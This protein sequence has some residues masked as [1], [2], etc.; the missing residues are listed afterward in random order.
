MLPP[1]LAEMKKRLE[2]K[3]YSNRTAFEDSVLEELD[4][5]DKDLSVRKSVDDTRFSEPRITAGPS[6]SCPCC[7]R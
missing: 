7:G 1:A 2:A 5:L 6:G 3:G 4:V